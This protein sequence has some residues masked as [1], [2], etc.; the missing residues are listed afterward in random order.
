M[1]SEACR[2]TKIYVDCPESYLINCSIMYSSFFSPQQLLIIPPILLALTVHECAHAWVADKLGDPT[3]RMMGRV[4]LNPIRHLDP[5]GTIMLF[6]SGMF[7]WAKP[8]P[9]NPM[10][11]A[12]PSRGMMLTSIAGPAANL[13]L[14]AISALILKLFTDT[15]LGY[16]V[17]EYPILGA[18]IF[19]LYKSIVIN[20]SLAAFN[21]FPIPPLDGSKALMHFLPR[22]QALSLMS[23]ERYGFMILLLLVM[24]GV[25]GRVLGPIVRFTVNILV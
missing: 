22:R 24:T 13:F 18:F 7:G 6:L 1:N 11:F 20:I 23:L 25:V 12:D 9:V 21:L 16:I 15:G 3:A 8:V 4:T 17:V 19:M 10:N 5:I 14:A 2:R